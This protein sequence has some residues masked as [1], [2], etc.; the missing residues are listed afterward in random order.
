MI[1]PRA[2][3]ARKADRVRPRSFAAASIAS[4]RAAS[5]LT[6]ARTV[7]PESMRSGRFRPRRFLR[8]PR[9]R[10][11]SSRGVC[12]TPVALVRSD[13]PKRLGGAGDLRFGGC[14]HADAARGIRD[15]HAPNASRPIENAD[16]INQSAAPLA[17]LQPAAL[18]IDRATPGD[19]SRWRG[20]TIIFSGW[21]SFTKRSWLP[22]PVLI[23]PSAFRRSAIFRALVSTL[24]TPRPFQRP[25]IL[26]SV[27]R[28]KP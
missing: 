23:Q 27:D 17:H 20:T 6:L 28:T 26:V 9:S 22:P 16:V 5:K 21:D 1:F 24:V 13:V 3:L 25:N 11:R 4:S 18:A 2:A 14:A 12:R 19:I 7:R 10:S 8:R 15:S